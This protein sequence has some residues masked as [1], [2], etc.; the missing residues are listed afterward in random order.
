MRW[1]MTRWW[2]VEIPDFINEWSRSIDPQYSIMISNAPLPS[3]P[4]FPPLCEAAMSLVS[5]LLVSIDYSQRSNALCLAHHSHHFSRF[6]WF[7][8]SA[9]KHNAILLILLGRAFEALAVATP[10]SLLLLFAINTFDSL[11]PYHR[12][13]LWGI[14][15]IAFFFPLG[16]EFQRASIILTLRMAHREQSLGGEATIRIDACQ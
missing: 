14:A 11:H 5:L 10:W 8:R 12:S 3:P 7:I 2:Q 4:P 6:T 15:I 9:V 13:C 1:D 16:R